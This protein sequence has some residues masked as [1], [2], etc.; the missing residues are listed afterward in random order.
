MMLL[1]N[2]FRTRKMLGEIN[3]TL[4]DKFQVIKRP[5]TRLD[6]TAITRKNKLDVLLKPLATLFINSRMNENN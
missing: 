4:I 6:C 2:F 1:R 3:A 5:W